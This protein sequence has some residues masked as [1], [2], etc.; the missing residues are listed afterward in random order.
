[1]EFSAMMIPAVEPAWSKQFIHCDEDT[2]VRTGLAHTHR[3]KTHWPQSVVEF[4]LL[5]FR[6]GNHGVIAQHIRPTI[7]NMVC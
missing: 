3:N 6:L 7:V 4:A 5:V 2:S 1:M